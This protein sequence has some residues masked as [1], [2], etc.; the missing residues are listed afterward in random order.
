[1]FSPVIESKKTRVMTAGM[2]G[3]THID[4]H[5]KTLIAY[6]CRYWVIMPQPSRAVGTL[7][8][9]RGS[10][11]MRATPPFRCAAKMRTGTQDRRQGRCAPRTRPPRRGR[12]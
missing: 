8:V 6:R 11:L 7:D 10:T 9:S 3:I 4:A 2:I 12:G 5:M 1:M